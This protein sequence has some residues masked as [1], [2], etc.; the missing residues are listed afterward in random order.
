MGAD[1]QED[2]SEFLPL[3]MDTTLLHPFQRSRY[4]DDSN[5]SEW[6]RAYWLGLGMFLILAAFW[7]LDTL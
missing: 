4:A 2:E 7:L 3:E 6:I 1:Y 5:K